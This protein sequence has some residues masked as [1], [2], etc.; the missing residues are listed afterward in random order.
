MPVFYLDIFLAVELLADFFLICAAAL[1]AGER[2]RRLRF[3]LSALLSAALSLVILFPPLKAAPLALFKLLSAAAVT[4]AAFGVA[5]FKR[6]LRAL[7]SFLLA[8][9]LF[10][11][12]V[13]AAAMAFSQPITLNNLT[14]YFGAKPLALLLAIGGVYAAIRVGMAVWSRG[15]PKNGTVKLLLQNGCQSIVLSAFIDTGNR[16]CDVISGR[17]VAVASMAAAEKLL[18]EGQKLVVTCFSQGTAPPGGVKFLLVPCE[19]ASGSGLMAAFPDIKIY[20]LS[21]GKQRETDLL[22]A[23]SDQKAGFDM[24]VGYDAVRCYGAG[25]AI[26]KE[27]TKVK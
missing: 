18:T 8:S 1:I 20:I 17:S 26:E 22:L 21:S 9:A 24:L 15:I 3:F 5:P 13:Y 6:F 27:R 2:I 10:G 7:G 12:A 14:Y 23:V 16:L 11:G 25:G 4:S 19:T